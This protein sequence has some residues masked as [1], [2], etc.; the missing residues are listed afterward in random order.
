MLKDNLGHWLSWQHFPC[1]EATFKHPSFVL[2]ITKLGWVC[3]VQQVFWAVW[4]KQLDQDSVPAFLFR[5]MCVSFEHQMGQT[6]VLAQIIL[7]KH[8]SI[9]SSTPKQNQKW[10]YRHIKFF[11]SKH[12]RFHLVVSAMD[13]F[14]GKENK[15][16][17]S[18]FHLP[19][20]DVQRA[21]HPWINSHCFYVGLSLLK[22]L[23]DG[24]EFLFT[25]FSVPSSDSATQSSII[26]CQILGENVFP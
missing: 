22:I 1:E 24:S 7:F 17:P 20:H 6:R 10:H 4:K 15:A 3:K 21:T 16:C 26:I 13:S 23:G 19:S 5:G 2:L 11:D 25:V 14:T 12:E 9:I 18:F 8:I